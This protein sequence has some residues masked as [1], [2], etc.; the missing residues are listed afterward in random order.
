MN[1]VI[2]MRVARPTDNLSAIK[3]MYLQGLEFE[4]LAEFLDHDG[5]DGVVLGHLSCPYHIEFTQKVDHHVGHAPSKDHLL[6]F[7]L[8]DP[9]EWQQRC[10]KMRLA[11][12]QE[13]QSFNPYWDRKGKTFEDMDGY[14]VVIENSA[15]ER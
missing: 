6:V 10:A 7:Y 9:E 8:A 4:V 12:F 5:F 1:Q 14:R 15:W 3:K 2:T 11:G 13:V